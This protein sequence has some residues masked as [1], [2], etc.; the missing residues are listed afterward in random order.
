V[1]KWKA[2][3]KRR[4]FKLLRS[5][6]M[7]DFVT[8]GNAACGTSSIFFCLNYLE[9]RL[10][11]PYIIASFVLLPLALLFDIMDGHVARYRQNSSP[12][13]SDLDSLADVISFSVAPAVLGFTLGLR[14][15]WDCIL[16]AFF[17]CAGVSRLARYNVTAETLAD[18][19]TGKVKF[20]QGF[21]VPTSLALVVLL[22]VAYWQGQCC[23]QRKALEQ[24]QPVACFLL[25]TLRCHCFISLSLSVRAD[26]VLGNMWLGT[27]RWSFP[28]TLPG[29]FHPFSLLFGFFG[30]A[31]ISEWKIPK[32]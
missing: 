26:G 6:T 13:G 29:T 17:V 32:P 31:M 25:L 7:A 8:L 11:E 4:R 9:N 20:Y 14:G 24:P 5:F 21:P 12:Y 23:M 2:D 22:A 18:V 15:V 3:P 28:A 27:Y 1:N 30:C 19:N 16:L 10:Y